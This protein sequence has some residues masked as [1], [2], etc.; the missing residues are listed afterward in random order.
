MAEIRVK[1]AVVG[2]NE[3][4]K[5]MRILSFL[6]FSPK[7]H[8]IED[9]TCA[10]LKHNFK[11]TS[12]TVI[13]DNQKTEILVDDMLLG[14]NLQKLYKLP[15]QLQKITM[16]SE[17]LVEEL[18]KR[19]FVQFR[20]EKKVKVMGPAQEQKLF[21]IKKIS[22]LVEKVE[23]ANQLQE[24]ASEA[25]ENLL[26]NARG[27][28]MNAAEVRSYVDSIADAGA[29]EAITAIS[30]LKASDQT[31]AHCVE[32]ASIFNEIYFKCL[33]DMGGSSVFTDPKEALLGGFLHDFGKSKV[34]KDVL[35]STVRFERDSEEMKLMQSHPF[36]GAELLSDMGMPSYIINMAHYHHV[37][38]DPK[39]KSS[40]PKDVGDVLMETQ[41]LA[42]VDIYQA[43]VGKRK[44]K[45]AWSPPE[46]IKY[47]D[48]LSGIEYP[49]DL[50]GYFQKVIGK[51]PKSS[52]V[53]LSD[54]SMGFVMN[55]PELNLDRPQIVIV[56]NGAGELL[57]SNPMIDLEVEQDMSIAKAL[58]A[59][60]EFGDDALDIFSNLKVS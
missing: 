42:M 50:F 45:K 31:Y 35:D 2:I 13:R 47:L 60:D 58:D 21:D 28:S 43:L 23:V 41:L 1:H 18:K 37:K 9:K 16:V 22:A 34:P 12:A 19:G 10:W 53:E 15:P 39:I 30:S 59:T 44:Y 54:A 27:G 52:L 25:V 55:V 36:F 46:T 24:E 57:Q 49:M 48:A 26:D 33:S 38:L 20:I 3:L 56:K 51:Y 29:S 7:Y 11:G 40:Y 6:E 17:R 14:D 32:V 8:D 4:K 5:G